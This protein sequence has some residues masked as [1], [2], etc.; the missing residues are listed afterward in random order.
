MLLIAV[1]IFKLVT[2]YLRSR[3]AVVRPRT[4]TACK[5]WQGSARVTGVLG[6]THGVAAIAVFPNFLNFELKRSQEGKEEKEK[7]NEKN[8][9]TE[10][11]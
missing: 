7:G 6:N 5:V 11:S 10:R 1:K 2:A 3:G 4:G 8:K 9:L